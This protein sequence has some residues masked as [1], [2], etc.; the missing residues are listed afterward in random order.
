M[1]VYYNVFYNR[2]GKVGAKELKRCKEEYDLLTLIGKK[3]YS[4]NITKF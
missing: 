3:Y 4:K 2:T 1:E